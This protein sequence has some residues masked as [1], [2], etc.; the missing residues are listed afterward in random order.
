MRWCFSRFHGDECGAAGIDLMRKSVTH[1]AVSLLIHV[2]FVYVMLKWLDWGVYG[3][4]IGN[5]TFGPG[6]L[7]T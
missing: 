1:S 4:V 3:L 7:H 6:G 2:I 5:V